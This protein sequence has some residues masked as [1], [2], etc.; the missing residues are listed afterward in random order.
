MD[1]YKTSPY[2]QRSMQNAS[3]SG[4]DA[5]SSQGLLGSSAA[6][7]N[8]QQSSSDIMNK[9][10]SEYLQDLMKKYMAGVGIGKDM[11]GIGATTAGNMSNQAMQMGGAMGQA[12]Y[13]ATNAPGDMARDLISAA[14]KA[15]G[16]G[17]GA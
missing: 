1:K 14:A 12:K 5:A 6:T 16:G 3:A 2:A 9:D 7:Q 10:R 13:G 15:Y 17:G 8:I 11:Y 4:L